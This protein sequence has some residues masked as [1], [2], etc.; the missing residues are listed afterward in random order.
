MVPNIGQF[1]KEMKN[2]WKVLEQGTE[3]GMRRSFGP[4]V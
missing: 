4:I 3:E 1:G 2:C